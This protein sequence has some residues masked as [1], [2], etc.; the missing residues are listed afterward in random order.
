[1]KIGRVYK[2]V[3]PEKRIYIGSTVREC[4]DR[5][6]DYKTL[7]CKSQIRLYNSFIKHGVE[8]HIFEQLWE[9]DINEMFKIE[10]ILGRLY[11]V[12]D[13][14][15]GLN[16]QLPKESDI[17]SCISEETREKM[18]NSA[19]NKP[20]VSEE[21]KL[22]MSQSLK[23]PSQETRNRLSQS[24]KN[25]KLSQETKDKIGR[26]NKGKKLSKEH[27]EIIRKNQIGKKSMLGKNHS[28][29]TKKKMSDAKLNIKQSKEHRKKLDNARKKPIIQ[30]DMEGNFIKEWDSAIS[31]KKELGLSTSSICE[32]CK[33]KQ[34]YSKNFKFKYKQNE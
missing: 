28:E 34:Q 27:I 24:K 4:E 20:P 33:N 32:C 1:M 30:M 23:N 9:G 19:K 6:K 13:R 26:A 18:S 7:N 25:K 8:N 5:W 29:I 14:E 2:I 17:Y 22:K 3:S 21:T 31:I 10:A 15:K 12:L 11:N 16:L